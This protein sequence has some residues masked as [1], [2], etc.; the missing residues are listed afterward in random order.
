MDSLA[1]LFFGVDGLASSFLTILND[2]LR[3]G[4]PVDCFLLVFCWGT[5]SGRQGATV[6]FWLTSSTRSGRFDRCW[7][8]CGEAEHVGVIGLGVRDGG[9]ISSLV[10]DKS[11]D[12][13]GSSLASIVVT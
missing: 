7:L 6:A 1:G 3:C 2:P 12:F 13:S 11:V 9:G 8:R 5:T 4:E 10:T